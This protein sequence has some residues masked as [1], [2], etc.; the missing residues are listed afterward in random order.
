MLNDGSILIDTDTETTGDATGNYT[1]K[2][3][4]KTDIHE[5]ESRTYKNDKDVTDEIV[6]N[7][8]ETIDGDSVS[9][10]GGVST[11][12][13]G[14]DKVIESGGKIY[15]GGS[16]DNICSLLLAAVDEIINLQTFGPPPMHK[17]HPT[18]IMNLN[19][20]KEKI[21]ALFLEGA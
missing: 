17:I 6:G 11:E 16:A 12:K 18:S 4:G 1:R 8:T 21:K 15:I 5:K 3:K 19:A 9:E 7:H 2:I 10:I 20:Y 14:G 13:T